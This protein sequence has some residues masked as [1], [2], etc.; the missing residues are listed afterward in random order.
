[1]VVRVLA[2]QEGRARRAAQ[3]N[4]TNAFVK[5][6]PRAPINARVFDI[7]RKDSSVWSSV[8]STT[9]FGLS[10][11]AAALVVLV[12]VAAPPTLNVAASP[13]ASANAVRLMTW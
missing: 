10:G 1:M 7:T 11:G 12:A 4:D 9:M 6:D 2:R 13:A 8:M 5:V 3:R